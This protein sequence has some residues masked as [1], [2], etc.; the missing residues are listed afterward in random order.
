MRFIETRYATSESDYS[1][2]KQAVLSVLGN[3]GGNLSSALINVFPDI[4]FDVEKFAIPQCTNML[5]F[6]SNGN[7]DKH[8]QAVSERRLF[9][10]NFANSRGFDALVPRNW[11]SINSQDIR[12]LQVLLCKFIRKLI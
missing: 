9:F 6:D 11:Y 3:F 8:A 12:T 1:N 2:S 10:E 7:L 5:L 4:T